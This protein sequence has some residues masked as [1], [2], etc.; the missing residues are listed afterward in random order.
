[1]IETNSRLLLSDRV[2][3]RN[4]LLRNHS[5]CHSRG[6]Q[7]LSLIHFQVPLVLD[8]G[9]GLNGLVEWGQG[10]L[11]EQAKLTIAPSESL[12]AGY[13]IYTNIIY[14]FWSFC[15]ILEHFQANSKRNNSGIAFGIY[16]LHRR[17][18]ILGESLV[19]EVNRI[20]TLEG[21]PIWFEGQWENT[22]PN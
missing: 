14:N 20:W 21:N 1:M 10:S 5:L 15:Q 2:V 4:G 11:W 18:N 3:Q 16:Y 13:I 19:C 17:T 9:A 6:Y 22:A 8:M 7:A 12:L